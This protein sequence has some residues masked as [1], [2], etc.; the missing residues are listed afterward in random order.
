VKR[1]L[2]P[3]VVALLAT[4]LLL[5][6]AGWLAWRALSP[7]RPERSTTAPTEAVSS[8][9]QP[10]TTTPD[11]T[12]EIR[13]HILGA[14]G[15][16][17]SGATVRLVAP[18][19]PYAVLRDTTS[20]PQGAFSFARVAPGRALVV[21]DRD[22]AGFVTS[23]VLEATAGQSTD[24]TLVLSSTSGVRGTVVDAERRPVAGATISVEGMPWTVPT[25]TSNTAGAFHLVVVPNE[26][27]SLVAEAGGYDAAHVALVNRR[28]G[29]DLALSI[30]LSAG[31]GDASHDE[32]ATGSIEGE[33]VDERGFGVPSY[34]LAVHSFDAAQSRRTEVGAPR[35]V[36]DP[37]GAFRLDRLAPGSYTLTAT[38]AGKPPKRSEP[39][40]VKSGDS[41]RGVRLVLAPGGSVNGTVTDRQQH[42]PVAGA[43][44]FFETPEGEALGATKTD[45]AGRY[46]LDQA[47]PGALTIRVQKTGFRTRKFSGLQVR[48]GSTLSRD[49]VLIPG[50][51]VRPRSSGP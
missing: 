49:F 16:P 51:D 28:E 19:A 27:T 11:A 47:T 37:R 41:I 40:D 17:V 12:P 1:R 31:K 33:V 23:A 3:I 42:A 46:H 13:G 20:D 4:L 32:V 30:R 7:D 18:A 14:E 15:N 36:D 44:V 35:K 26:A 29:V 8:S 48:S 39:I 43:D 45:E 2:S 21:A 24:V 9:S 34:T 22:P 25:T 6:L 10:V 5:P 50:E 38:A